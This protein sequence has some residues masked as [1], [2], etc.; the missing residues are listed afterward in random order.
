MTV[1]AETFALPPNKIIAAA[2]AVKIFGTFIFLTPF[3]EIYHTT[4]NFC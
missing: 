3:E 2:V 1:S 4:M